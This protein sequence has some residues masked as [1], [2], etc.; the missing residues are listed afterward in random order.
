M[1]AGT[2]YGLSGA[3][4][5]DDRAKGDTVL[6]CLGKVCIGD[7]GAETSDIE[8][9]LA[10]KGMC[11]RSKLWVGHILGR[12]GRG[13]IGGVRGGHHGRNRRNRVVVLLAVVAARSTLSTCHVL[14]A[15]VLATCTLKRPRLYLVPL[16]SPPIL[17][18][19]RSYVLHIHACTLPRRL[20]R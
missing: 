17:S 14:H 2:I 19:L 18:P 5:D 15:R 12:R 20:K 8:L 3:I 16:L 9:G 1:L 11:A 13:G 4:A 6:E 7:L 10:Q